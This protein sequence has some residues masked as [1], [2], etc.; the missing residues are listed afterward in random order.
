MFLWA[1]LDQDLEGASALFWQRLQEAHGKRL[2]AAGQRP[3]ELPRFRSP[4]R[5][6][7]PRPIDHETNAAERSFSFAML[8]GN[9]DVK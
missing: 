8:A 4:G 9:R 2:R 6:N 5:D 1:P 3:L 7:H